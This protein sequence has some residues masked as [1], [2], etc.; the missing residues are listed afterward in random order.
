MRHELPT[1]YNFYIVS[2]TAAVLARGMVSDHIEGDTELWILAGF[3]IGLSWENQRAAWVRLQAT[4][5]NAQRRSAQGQ[6][7]RPENVNFGSRLF[8]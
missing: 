8:E 4:S 1:A 5:K 7:P 6:K 3:I 2:I